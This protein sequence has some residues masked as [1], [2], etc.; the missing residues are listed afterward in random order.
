VL[1]MG[2]SQLV[3]LEMKCHIQVTLFLVCISYSLA[4]N[5]L[6][7]SSKLPE[8]TEYPIERGI[9]KD[10]DKVMLLWDKAFENLGVKGT[11]HEHP[12]LF[13]EPPLVPKE[14]REKHTQIAF[15]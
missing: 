6:V 3:R 10:W 4:I 2:L 11:E 1:E 5:R 7:F 15:E 12:W 8:F 13:I 14:Q 9:V